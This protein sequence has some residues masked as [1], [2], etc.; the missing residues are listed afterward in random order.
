[1]Q[2]VEKLNAQESARSTVYRRLADAFR[3]PSASQWEE[4]EQ[5]RSAL[6][7]LGSDSLEDAGRLKDSFQALPDKGVLKV[8]YAKL[9]IG[10]F[11][12][13]APPYGSVY[14]EKDR[15]LMGDSTIDVRQHYLSR[16]LDLASDF[17]EAPDH[18]SAEL[19][20]MCFLIQQSLAAINQSDERLLL[21]LIQQ[22][23]V[24][25][26][27]HLGAWIPDFASRIREHCR[28]D[29]YRY[30]AIVAQTFIAEEIEMIQGITSK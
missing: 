14:L 20:F 6:A 15:R 28:I 16:G 24:F 25:L 1:M 29:F 2:L 13:P 26:K 23:R 18:V 19:E 5:L 11:M 30:L 9:F 4:L 22:Q 8:E 10:P 3:P 7:Y 21:E 27:A 12:V 17:K